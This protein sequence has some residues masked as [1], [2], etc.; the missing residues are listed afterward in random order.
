MGETVTIAANACVAKL[1]S[2]SEAVQAS[3]ADILSY[4]VEAG[5]GAKAWNGRSSF[6]SYNSTSFPAG[7]VHLVQSVLTQQGHTI[8]HARKKLP[9]PLGPESPV[10]DEFGNDDPNYDFQMHALRQ[11]E[12]HGC[13]IIQ[14]A[15]GG[16][17]SKIG[18]LIVARYRRPSLFLTTRGVLMYQMKTA[19]ESAGLNTGIVGDGEC[20]FVRGANV[21]MVQTFLARLVELDLHQEMRA[22]L[23]RDAKAVEKAKQKGLPKPKTMTHA[24]IEA[25]ARERVADQARTRAITIKF[26]EQIEVVIGEEA[27]EVGGQSYYSILKHCKNA[28]IRVALTATPFMRDD[29]EDNM[30]LMAA[31]GPILVKVS[32]K[33]LI[34][35]GILAKPYFLYGAPDCHPKLHKTSPWQRARELEIV[36]GPGRNGFILKYVQKAKAHGLSV[37]ILVQ[38]I[39]HGNILQEL[40]GAAG[41]TVRY[42]RG[43]SDQDDRERCLRALERGEIDAAIGTTIVDVG[44][45]VPS[46]GMLINAGG[47]K[48]EIAT[49]QR[50]GRV[51]RRK[52]KGP[53]VSFVVDFMDQRNDYLRDHSQQRRAIVEGTPGFA[54]G[55]LPAGKDFPWELFSSA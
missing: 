19:F 12:K 45:D 41:M 29:A 51:L 43:E 53:N 55:V 44:V 28:L 13:G 23:A 14:V 24:Q 21:G 11:V 6:F 52:K 40:L 22:Q 46:V 48:A 15:T 27:H 2:S 17:K 9:E 10:V 4:P 35:R 5:F 8:R 54:E 49:R 36:N 38:T 20:K 42:I 30:R 34:D 26:L 33:L 50:I 3:V 7:F 1:I 25:F 16:G 32:E 47:G 18:K 39:E 31:F 37:L